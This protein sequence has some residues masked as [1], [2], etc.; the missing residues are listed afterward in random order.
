MPSCHFVPYLNFTELCNID[1]DNGSCEYPEVNYDCD[2]MCILEID[3][4]NVCG[5]S[6]EYDDCVICDGEKTLIGGVLQHIEEAGIHS[7]D[8]SCSFPPYSVGDTQLHELKKEGNL[9]KLSIKTLIISPFP[10][11]SSMR[12]NFLGEPKLFQKLIST[13]Q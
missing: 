5:G 12:L 11:P 8:S 10:A 4:N 13:F 6:A 3:C 1:F 7:G 9:L 2:G